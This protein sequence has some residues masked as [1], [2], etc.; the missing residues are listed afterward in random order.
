M[1]KIGATSGIIALVAVIFS[2]LP[3][4]A[5]GIHV[6]PFYF[7]F[8]LAWHHR[9]HLYLR[10]NP[11]EART[12]RNEANAARTG[13]T[14]RES[15]TETSTEVLAS[16]PGV[17]PDVT[18]PPI[19][20]IRKTVH[21][22]ADQE[23]ALH[24]LSAASSQASDVIKSSCPASVPLTPVGRLD[25]VEQRLNATVK[26]IQ[27]VR[28]PLE[29]FYQALND[30]QKRQFSTISS[31]VE[32]AGSAD[33]RALCSQQ[34]GSFIKLPVQRIEE[35]VQPT[36]QQQSALDDLKSATQN[37]GDQLQSSCSTAIPKSPVAR[38]DTVETRLNTV[39]DAIRAIRPSLKNFYASLSDDQKAK[40]N[41]I[42][43][44]EN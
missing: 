20:Q 33:M 21:P 24:D 2:P 42:G 30:E 22:T 38:L 3:I 16:C 7:H 17:A 14:D 10:T 4:A 34:A 8:P 25:A 41:M 44:S 31:P 29:R 1:R 32:N 19:D 12:R 36:A 15:R 43:P 37:A 35:V 5:F 6:G 13:P 18:S 26:A 9:H 23:A 39:A 40:F 27:I 28:S 11:N